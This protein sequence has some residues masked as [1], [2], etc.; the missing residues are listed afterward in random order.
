MEFSKVTLIIGRAYILSCTFFLYLHFL[1]KLNPVLASYWRWTFYTKST[2]LIYRKSIGN[3]IFA[4]CRIFSTLSK[5]PTPAKWRYCTAVAEVDK[6]PTPRSLPRHVLFRQICEIN[7]IIP[8]DMSRLFLYSSVLIAAG[9]YFSR[10]IIY[11][12]LKKKRCKCNILL[13][14]Y[15]FATINSIW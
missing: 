3:N 15:Y 4:L 1:Q 5:I 14:H 11:F 9:L 7:S 2:G 10:E 13:W 6:L 8:S 12:K